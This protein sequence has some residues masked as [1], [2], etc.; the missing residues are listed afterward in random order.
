MPKLNPMVLA[1]MCA[2]SLAGCASSKAPAERSAAVEPVLAVN[3][4]GVSAEGLFRLGRY[5]EGQAR[6]EQAIFAYRE[7]LR[8]DPLQ[9]EVYNRLGM[10]L[11]ESGRHAEAIHEF[12]AAIALASNRADLYNNLGFAYLLAGKDAEAA[13]ALE[14]AQRLE[15]TLA[16]VTDNLRIAKT[17]L[18]IPATSDALPK[19]TAAPVAH[20]PAVLTE[21]RVRLIEVSPR[22][23]ELKPPVDRRPIEVT[24]L[25]F[26]PEASATPTEQPRPPVPHARSF[27]LEVSNGNGITG[28][29]KR[30]SEHLRRVGVHTQ[31]LTN[32][33]PFEQQHTVIHYRPGFEREAEILKAKLQ[34]EVRAIAS[35]ALAG[36]I[37]V[38][39]VLGRDVL[40]DTALLVPTPGRTAPATVASR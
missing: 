34:P 3:H 1:V 2:L 16:K 30:V 5:F 32:D 39:L 25:P 10:L 9:V 7:A 13:R 20:V 31:R 35:K 17:R 28:M 38:R 18:A 14:E 26:P 27:R 15:P 33:R 24:P 19:T 36:H 11:G 29:A 23:F 40:S 37:D 4:G 21:D 6:R 22:V 12:Q 8:R